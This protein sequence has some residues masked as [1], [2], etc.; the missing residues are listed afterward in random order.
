[1]FKEVLA[2]WIIIQLILIG[3]A[4]G[5]FSHDVEARTYKCP[6]G[7]LGNSWYILTVLPLVLFVDAGVFDEVDKYCASLT[8]KQ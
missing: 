7:K 4:A 6:D 5:S 1:M 3:F 8:P 2:L